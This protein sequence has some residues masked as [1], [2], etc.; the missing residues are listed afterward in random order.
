MGVMLHSVFLRGTV[1]VVER[2]EQQLQRPE[3]G[4]WRLG[5]GVWM[6]ANLMNAADLRN[7]LTIH[8]PGIECIVITSNDWAAM[9]FPEPVGWIQKL[10]QRGYI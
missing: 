7:Y 6:I 4:F 2:A 9:G 3:W 10:E 1:P 8:A 5:E